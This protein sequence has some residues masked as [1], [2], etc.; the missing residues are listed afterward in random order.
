MMLV[1]ALFFSAETDQ[2]ENVRQEVVCKRRGFNSVVHGVWLANS[3]NTSRQQVSGINHVCLTRLLT[4]IRL[5]RFSQI[6]FILKRWNA[7]NTFTD[8][9]YYSFLFMV[10]STYTY[11]WHKR[12]CLVYFLAQFWKAGQREEKFNFQYWRD[13]ALSAVVVYN[14]RKLPLSLFSFAKWIHWKLYVNCCKV[15]VSET[16]LSDQRSRSVDHQ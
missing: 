2:H 3:L 13:L 11:A 4:P 16:W 7:F 8:K 10:L 6:D 5:E 15:L 12:L 1:I 9:V 14:L